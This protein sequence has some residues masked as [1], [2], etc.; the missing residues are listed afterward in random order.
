MMFHSYLKYLNPL[1]VFLIGIGMQAGAYGVSLQ[2]SPS[3]LVKDQRANLSLD[4]SGIPAGDSVWFERYADLDGNG[5]IAPPDFFMDRFGVT[6]GEFAEMGGVSNLNVPGDEDGAADGRIY[7]II[8]LNTHPADQVAPAYLLRAVSLSNAFPATIQGYTL[9]SPA[10]TQ[11][12][13]G[14]VL[15][16][17]VALPGAWIGAYEPFRGGR[18]LSATLSDSQ[19]EYRLSLPA[20]VYQ[21]AASGT[22]LVFNLN[23]HPPI[24]LATNATEERNLELMRTDL[25]FS[26]R[27]Q[28][29][30]TS[31]GLAAGLLRL[32]SDHGL[33]SL[34][35]AQ[36]DGSFSVPVLPGRWRL[37][38]EEP[39]L[40][41]AGYLVP[42][43][44]SYYQIGEAGL[45]ALNISIPKAKALITGKVTDN[46]NR[47]IS[48]LRVLARKQNPPYRT[49]NVSDPLG[50]FL[51]SV[52]EGSWEIGP[53]LSHLANRGL[54]APAPIMVTLTNGAVET[55]IMRLQ[56]P[57]TRWQGRA[58]TLENQAASLVLLQNIGPGGLRSLS[59]SDL[60]GEFTVPV[61][62]GDWQ[63]ALESEFAT[64]NGLIRH[65]ISYT[66]T[67][68]TTPSN[69]VYHVAPLQAR[70][71]GTV[72]DA[73]GNPLTNQPV[74]LQHASGLTLVDVTN[75]QG[76][77]DMGVSGG[78]WI[79]TLPS[80]PA[81]S[82]LAPTVWLEAN[83]GADLNNVVLQVK[84]S[85]RRLAGQVQ[86]SSAN[87]LRNLTVLA[88]LQ[89]GGTHYSARATTDE[90]G[91]FLINAF[92]GRW[93]VNLLPE[94]LA[95][96]GW[97]ASEPQTVDLTS[98][99]G[100]IQLQ[101]QP[102]VAPA[103][104]RLSLPLRLPGNQ[105]QFFI[106][107]AS[108][109]TYTI[110][111]SFDLVEWNDLSQFTSKG[112][113]FSYTHSPSSL[114]DRRFYRV[115]HQP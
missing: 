34:S 99:N 26:G 32:E 64:A 108:N 36:P 61:V 52:D 97:A 95:P 50:Q 54:I 86:D 75:P 16:S 57:Q 15:S 76:Q 104:A 48:E 65:I 62:E 49:V 21:I 9:S 100:F 55:V 113:P 101:L 29:A 47:T 111:T 44:P 67:D 71:Q 69:L 56:R 40:L 103:P 30:E 43:D 94:E 88:Q 6:D 114:L 105:V 41:R 87:P 77:Y 89:M 8:S 31:D 17:N 5:M 93:E 115:I 74:Q 38:F 85:N 45:S 12:I 84:Q 1:W 51:L 59:R 24:N 98:D 46:L 81:P 58:V 53:D 106:T 83:P 42:N 33:I 13:Q 22:G 109:V 80:L 11:S 78:S 20:G 90:M 28:D 112:E 37:A 27:I 72:L 107:G 110:Q 10:L 19:G 35:F 39:A 3:Q 66:V 82:S 96:A 14:K 60:A 73:S 91:L 63:I 102:V 92:E 25:T 68:G 70:V 18:L 2:I 7:S 23:A 4:L 79:A